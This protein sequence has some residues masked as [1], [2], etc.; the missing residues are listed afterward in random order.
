C[1][2]CWASAGKCDVTDWEWDFEVSDEEYDR[3][4][5][6]AEKEEVFSECREVED[7]YD[8]LYSA[9]LREQADVY[10]G[11]E[12]LLQEIAEDL[13]LEEDDEITEEQVIDYLEQMYVW[14]INFPDEF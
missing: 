1:F 12:E 8:R 3:L 7:I 9:M 4:K 2:P 14:G 5:S 11:S 13:E 10:L 6:A